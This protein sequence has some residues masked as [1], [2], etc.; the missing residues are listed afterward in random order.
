MLFTFGQHQLDLTRPRVM[1]VLNVTPDSFSDG[2]QHHAPEAALRHAERMLAEGADFIDVGGES[3]RPGATPVSEQEELDRVIPVVE[4]IHAHLD[5]VISVDTSC[6][7]VMTEAAGAGA[8]LINDVRALQRE[9][10]VQAVAAIGLPVCLMHMQGEPDTMQD[11]PSYQDVLA[12]VMGFLSQRAAA[13][14]AAGIG[15]DQIILDP[16]FGFGK[17][18]E[19]N[20]QLL[21]RLGEMQ[22]LGY[23][24]LTGLSRKRMIAAVLDEGTPALA[25]DPA[26]MAAAVICAMHGASIIRTH[27]VSLTRDAMRVVLQTLKERG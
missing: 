12:D 15:H 19:H 20:Y 27:N 3:T 5:V 21:N 14:E 6:P 4:R 24:L 18:L 23:P 17:T 10:A 25:R 13:C 7:A 2:G 1:G 16:G 8:G 26:S 11:S 22:S 9:G